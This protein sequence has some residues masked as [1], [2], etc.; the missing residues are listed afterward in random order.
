MIVVLVIGCCISGGAGA[1]I[2]TYA[3]PAFR[4]DSFHTFTVV[5]YASFAQNTPFKDIVDK[6]IVYEVRNAFEKIGYK[7]VSPEESPDIILS[8]SGASESKEMYVPSST[9]TVYDYVPNQEVTIQEEPGASNGYQR[10]P[11]TTVTVP[12]HSDSRTVTVPG[13]TT[14]GYLHNIEVNC[15]NPKTGATLWSSVATCESRDP[16]VR[17]LGQALLYLISDAFPKS[18]HAEEYYPTYGK[19]LGL[20]F[21]VFTNDGNSFY[22]TVWEV[23]RKSLAYKAK[24]KVLDEILSIDG[25]S[26][27]NKCISELH[28]MLYKNDD[29]PLTLQVKRGG[30]TL[31]TVLKTTSGKPKSK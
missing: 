22:P 24:L 19:N 1:T 20:S 12:G 6:Y 3:D 30:K 17:V 16:D 25:V 10:G 8:V 26:T 15:H 21:K 2:N 5:S 23:E 13:Y 27:L 9:Q 14:N 28:Y 11:E 18:C 7:Y 29:A 4:T 31:Q